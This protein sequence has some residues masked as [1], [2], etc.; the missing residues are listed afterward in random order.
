[1]EPKKIEALVISMDE[2]Q[3]DRCLEAV[4][5]QTA[6]VSNIVHING[7]VPE[8]EAFKKGIN[9]ITEDWVI[10]IA[11]DTILFENAVETAA[12]FIDRYYSLKVCACF[13]GLYDTFLECDIGFSNVYRTSAYKSIEYKDKLSND[14]KINKGLRAN[15]WEIKKLHHI[16]VGTHFDH[17]D[18]FQVFRRFYAQAI[19]Y[20][21]NDFVK[22]RMTE[23]LERTGN[24]LY[25]V[26]IK[27]ID[28]AK[29]KKV[30]PGSHNLD[31]DRKMF[32]EFNRCELQS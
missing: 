12:D 14:R 5:N 11:G 25:L 2:P 27:S 29:T 28:F 24:S 9:S 31:F 4:K 23:L 32:E 20:S 18:E 26:G 3:L 15:G 6:P 19:K 30:Y 13:F 22:K 16:V 7:I 8:V 21:N 10:H 17:P 1:M